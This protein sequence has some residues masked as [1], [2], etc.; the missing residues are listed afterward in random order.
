MSKS[1]ITKYNERRYLANTAKEA[2]EDLFAI[3]LG[4]G[5]AGIAEDDE[6]FLNKVF[7]NK[8]GEFAGWYAATQF[9][10]GVLTTKESATQADGWWDDEDNVFMLIELAS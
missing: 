2:A 5:L 6:I 4:C 8:T 9:D 7:D 1:V 10:D 3:M